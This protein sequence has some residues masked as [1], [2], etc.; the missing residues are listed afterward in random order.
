MSLGCKAVWNG[1]HGFEIGEGDDKHTVFI[2]KKLCTCRV[3]DV[4]GIPC[5]HAICAIKH[6]GMEPLDHISGYYHRAQ[7]DA[8]YSF[9]I[10]P[11]PGKKFM[12][13]DQYLPMDA[14][15]VKKQPGRPRKKRIINVNEPNPTSGSGK[16]A[17]KGQKQ[18]CRHCQEA[19]H[20]KASCKKKGKQGQTS[21]AGLQ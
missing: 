1:D 20:N 14:P 4:S 11:V 18:R 9:T 2:D 19:G 15:E 12:K 8:T 10:Q 16:L 7:Y 3:W 21:Q 17:R 13:C 5:P 6:L